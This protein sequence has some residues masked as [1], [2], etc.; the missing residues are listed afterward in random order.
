MNHPFDSEVNLTFGQLKDIVNRAL[1]GTLENTREKT[2]GQALAISWR[3]NRLVAARNK[4]HLK[5]KG[6]NALDIKGVSDKFQGRG[7]LSDAYNF[8]MRDLSKAISSLSQKQRDKIFKGGACFMN[9]EVIYPTSVNVVPYGQ[10]LLV[11]HGTMEYNEE[12]VAIGE[13]Q[14]AARMLAG[15]IKQVNQ[16]V[17]SSYTIEGPPVVKLPKSQDLSKKKSVY[18]G[19]IKRLQ[20]KYN[21]KDTDG[22][23]EYHQA[24]WENYVDKK[25]P[26]TLDNKT[27]MGLVKRWAFFDKKFRLDRKNIVDAKTLEWAKK[28]DKEKHSKIAKDNIRPFEDIFLGLGAEVLQFV[29]SALTVNP[30]KA[31]RDMKKKLDKT[32]KDVRKSGDEK[33]IQKLKLELQ[34][35]NSIGGAKKIV[36]N[37]GIVFTYNGK[38]FK[39]TGTFAPLNQ[40]LGIFF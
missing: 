30:D 7:G 23:A 20:K 39:L 16:N 6:E 35:L 29:S 25:S 24:F 31:I 4:G 21:L 37:E 14:G 19:K 22:V 18:S 27:K 40:I 11:F 33:K 34:R 38:T 3:D 28:T 17:Q 5:N 15:M 2:D 1:D 9:L 36:P 26:T 10:A 32:I 12:G 13:N 8:A